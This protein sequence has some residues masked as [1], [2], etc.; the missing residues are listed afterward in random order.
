MKRILLIFILILF[1]CQKEVDDLGFRTYVIPEGEH[2]SGT[3]INHPVNSRI[4]FKM[5]RS[6]EMKYYNLIYKNNN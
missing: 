2:S 5:F 1:S 4:T 3:F 6:E